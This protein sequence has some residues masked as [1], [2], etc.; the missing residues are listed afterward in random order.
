MENVISKQKTII[1]IRANTVMRIYIIIVKL[2][3]TT[4]FNN[5][6]INLNKICISKM[7]Q[8]RYYCLSTK[9]N[10]QTLKTLELYYA[11]LAFKFNT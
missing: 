10:I 1:L 2:V 9:L 5:Q 3:L 6:A 4:V 11:T 7:Y 8:L